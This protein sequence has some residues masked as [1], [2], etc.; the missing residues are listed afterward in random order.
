MASFSTSNG[1]TTVTFDY[2]ATTAKVQAVVGD[3]AE[4]LWKEVKDDEGV[5]TNPFS[6]ATNQ[7]KLDVVDAHVKGVVVNLANSFKSNKAQ[8]VAR[9]T[10]AADEHVL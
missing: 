10:E 9:D 3:A 1:D 5:V 2:T 6:S 8:D 7:E 4:D